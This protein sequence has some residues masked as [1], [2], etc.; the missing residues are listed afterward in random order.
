MLYSGV[1]SEFNEKVG[2]RLTSAR[3]AAG[4][5]REQ[6]SERLGKGFSLSTIQAHENGRNALTPE[7]ADR[8]VRLYKISHDWLV[9]GVGEMHSQAVD[10]QTAEI[11]DVSRKIHNNRLRKIWINTG[12]EMADDGTESEADGAA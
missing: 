4:L 12:R 7:K 2:E 9:T 11:L 6:V 3:Q 10:P 5:S 8:Y 1:M